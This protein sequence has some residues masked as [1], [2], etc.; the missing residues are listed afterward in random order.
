M[1]QFDSDTFQAAYAG[2]SI[3]LLPKEFALFQFLYE[4]A[5]RSFSRDELLDAVWPLEA[6][7]DRTV[8][9]HIYRIRKKLAVWSHLLRVETI[10]GQGYKLV[11]SAPRQQESPLLHDEQFAADVNRMLHKYHGLG[12]GAAMQLLAEHRE[13]LSLPGDPYY[14][15]Y[16]HFIRGDFEWLLTTDS[17][18]I[19]KKLSYALFI[20]SAIQPDHTNI[21][22]Y[23][24]ALIAKGSM[25]EREWINDL[26]LSVINHYIGEGKTEQAQEKL[27]AIRQDIVEM[28]SASF[29]SVF[30]LTE[31]YLQMQKGQIE[32]ASAKLQE[33]EMLLDQHPIQRERGALQV[34]KGILLYHQ[35]EKAAGREA[36]EQGLETT[37]QTRFI[38]HLLVNLRRV[39]FCIGTHAF[40][41]TYYLRLH[42]QW[43]Q[44][45]AQFHFDQLKARTEQLL[46]QHL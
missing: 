34:A 16:V 36:I 42:R 11:R 44:L 26:R 12:M 19:W 25:L 43:D 14:D 21:S 7:T 15:A 18:D 9:D 24:E 28:N 22:R 4:N 20:Y 35:G 1:V 38:P 17:M 2:E 10:R 3:Q 5:G 39:L 33:C 31:M 40:D 37:R 45:A 30:L 41:E 13:L 27:D 8:D 23:F 29:M 6:P 32:E 46:E